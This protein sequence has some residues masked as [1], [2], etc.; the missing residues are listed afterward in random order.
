MNKSR[1]YPLLLLKDLGALLGYS[2]IYIALVGFSEYLLFE[3]VHWGENVVFPGSVQIFDH[4]LFKAIDVIVL[5]T[6]FAKRKTLNL[7]YSRILRLDKRSILNAS[8]GIVFSALSI[9][10]ITAIMIAC[11]AVNLIYNPSYSTS[12]VILSF[13]L[14]I[15]VGFGEEFLMRGIW[16]EYLLKRHSKFTAVALSSGIFAALHLMNPN[17][18]ALSFLNLILAGV[19]LAQLYLLTKNIWLATLFHLGWNFFQGPVLGFAVSGLPMQSV[20]SQ[21]VKGGHNFINGGAFGLEG[22]IIDTGVAVVTITLLALL[23]YRK[24]A[25]TTHATLK[26][27]SVV[28]F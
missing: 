16:M 19:L 13:I 12:G 4:L 21:T 20:F 10:I 23:I 22:S 14:F 17:V 18:T 28:I 26:N 27:K 7:N 1:N 3:A 25:K 8:W 6:F 5:L 15:L 24:T 2:L 11:K 9:F